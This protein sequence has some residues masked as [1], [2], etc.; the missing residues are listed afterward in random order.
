M[1]G[2]NDTSS[3]AR[4]RFAEIAGVAVDCKIHV[5]ARVGEDSFFLHGKII[6]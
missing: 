6:Q 2:K 5:V 1:I 4:L 3:A